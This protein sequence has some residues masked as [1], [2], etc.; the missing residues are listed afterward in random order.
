MIDNIALVLFHLGLLVVVLRLLR[1]P[2]PDADKRPARAP[3]VMQAPPAGDAP[4]AR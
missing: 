1:W 3:R 4:G 2:D